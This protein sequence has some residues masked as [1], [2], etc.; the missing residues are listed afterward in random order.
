[1]T[2]K[3]QIETNRQNA[4]QSTGPRSLSGKAR[5]S[6]NAVKHGL[7]ATQTLLPGE[8]SEEFFG[9]RSAMFSSLNP[10]GALENQL[11]ERAVSLT[12]RLRRVPIFEDALFRWTLYYQ[13]AMHD[14]DKLENFDRTN[15]LSHEQDIE[16]EFQDGL[17]VGRM[18]ETLLATDLLGKLGRYETTMHNQLTQILDKLQRSKESNENIARIVEQEV[19]QAVLTNEKLAEK[20]FGKFNG[21]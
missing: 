20:R 14:P 5:S 3:K 10:Q 7:T 18:F 2:S 15:D 9:I 17:S 1:M 8:N 19:E 6:L 21:N 11:V 16:R 4:L 12:W 13:R